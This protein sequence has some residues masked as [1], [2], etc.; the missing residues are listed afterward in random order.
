MIQSSAKGKENEHYLW[1]KGR[2]RMDFYG[3]RGREKMH[4]YDSFV[5]YF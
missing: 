1:Q 2:G 4:A 3:G 5:R